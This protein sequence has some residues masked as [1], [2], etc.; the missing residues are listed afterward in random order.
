MPHEIRAT[1]RG[2]SRTTVHMIACMSTLFGCSLLTPACSAAP[3]GLRRARECDASWPL[4]DAHV[5]GPMERTGFPAGISIPGS[6]T[7]IAPL[8]SWL[9]SRSPP[10]PLQAPLAC[11]RPS[12]VPSSGIEMYAVGLARSRRLLGGC[13]SLTREDEHG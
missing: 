1:L 13:A 12:V 5:D 9:E 11:A 3:R 8:R 2:Y 10:P 4:R 7:W 6:L